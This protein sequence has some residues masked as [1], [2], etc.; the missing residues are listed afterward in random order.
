MEP[1]ND[2]SE[3]PKNKASSFAGI[4]FVFDSN[5]FKGNVEQKDIHR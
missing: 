3:N 1:Q 5:I 2:I 4:T